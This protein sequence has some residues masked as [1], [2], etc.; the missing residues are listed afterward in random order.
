VSDRYELPLPRGLFQAYAT[1]VLAFLIF[2]ALIVVPVSFSSGSIIAFPLPGFSTGWYAEAFRDI[3]WRNALENSLIIG[4]GAAL[5]ATMLGLSG[6][7]G[8]DR[9]PA[10][11]R[12]SA[13]TV[14]LLPFVMPVVL[15]ALGGYLGLA[16]LGLNNTYVGVIVLHAA[17]GVPF[18]V[19]SVTATLQGFDRNLW[20]AATGL[21]AVPTVAFR[22]VML[23]IIFPGVLTGAVFAFATSFDEVVVASFV[24]GPTQR[25]LPLHMFAGIKENTGPIVTAV[26]TLLL[27]LAG[28]F[29]VCVELLQRRSE[30]LRQG[31]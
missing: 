12:A 21:G 11:L 9:L 28:G 25:T 22:R 15:I 27:L 14:S 19:I 2:P 1:L 6:A 18:V 23:P 20:R 10:R 16:V 3:A 4:L 31:I 17:M 5:L 24:T 30:R 8:I 13:M 26:A 7:I 29:L